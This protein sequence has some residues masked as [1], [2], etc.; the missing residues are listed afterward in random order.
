[1]G[2]HRAIRAGKQPSQASRNRKSALA[3]K[4]QR[5]PDRRAPASVPNHPLLLSQVPG[6]RQPGLWRIV[7]A[8]LPVCNTTLLDKTGSDKIRPVQNGPDQAR[9]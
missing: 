6:C 7:P 3:A 8:G 1:M 9:A 4:W 5:T 2:L